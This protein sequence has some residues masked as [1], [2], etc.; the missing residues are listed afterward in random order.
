MDFFHNTYHS[1]KD[2]GSQ[3]INWENKRDFE[4]IIKPGDLVSLGQAESFTPGIPLTYSGHN[5]GHKI[6]A[7]TVFVDTI[8]K[9]VFCIFQTSTNTG[10]TI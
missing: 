8:S 3:H 5:S 7:V 1:V 6:K 10:E 9:G 2:P 4:D